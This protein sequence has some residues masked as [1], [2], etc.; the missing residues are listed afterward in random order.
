MGEIF[1]LLEVFHSPLKVGEV[2]YVGKERYKRV[3]VMCDCGC[4]TEFDI[5]PSYYR[6]KH[7][8]VN[9][10]HQARWMV[11]QRE[12]KRRLQK[13]CQL[14]SESPSSVSKAE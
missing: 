14:P 8:F 4:N 7:Y 12:E 10:A 9:H 3:H 6:R 11:K 13:L 1:E 5:Y 2:H